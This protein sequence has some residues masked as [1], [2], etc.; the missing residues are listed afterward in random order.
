MSKNKPSTLTWLALYAV[1]IGLA[2]AAVWVAFQWNGVVL[3]LA[4]W[5][6]SKPGLRPT[7]WTTATLPGINRLS[8]LI[9]GALWLMGVLFTENLLRA[10]ALEQRLI[11]QSVLLALILFAIWLGA[12]ILP[13]LLV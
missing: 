3:T 5:V 8:V 12:I 13:L 2:I 9:L 6:I 7:G 4:A 10:A 11:R 1:W